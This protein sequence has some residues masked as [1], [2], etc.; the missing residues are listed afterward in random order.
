[1]NYSIREGSITSSDHL[2]I[3]MKISINPIVDE[4]PPI[5]ILKR[6]NWDKIEEEIQRDMNNRS[7]EV[8]LR[9]GRRITKEIIWQ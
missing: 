2:P 3:I 5:R 4:E 7:E 8:N 1:M 9:E 6:A